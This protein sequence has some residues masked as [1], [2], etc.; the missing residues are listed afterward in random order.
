MVEE[1]GNIHTGHMRVERTNGLKEEG[2]KQECV[3]AGEWS[4]KIE[5]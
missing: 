5:A 1:E 4:G 3:E 2:S